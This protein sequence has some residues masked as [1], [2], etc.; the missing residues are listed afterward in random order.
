MK[1]LNS[2]PSNRPTKT[3]SFD[4]G[5]YSVGND[6]VDGQISVALKGN[7]YT[8]LVKNGSF[9]GGL[10]DWAPAGSIASTLDTTKAL[11]GTN[12]LKVN[13]SNQLSYRTQDILTQANH[14]IFFIC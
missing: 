7:T 2:L 14:K 1:K 4:G 9:E 3:V 5:I 11:I 10:T 6:V 12:S 13:V 8:N